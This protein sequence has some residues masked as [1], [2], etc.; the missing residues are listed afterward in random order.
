V[1]TLA[2]TQKSFD[3]LAALASPALRRTGSELR[4][5][6]LSVDPDATQLIWPKLKIASFG[7]GPK[8]N[9]QHYAYLA[10]HTNHLNLGFYHGASLQSHGLRLE[11]TGKNLRHVKIPGG[12]ILRRKALRSLLSEALEERQSNAPAV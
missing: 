12:T 5:L 2:T 4:K 11:G 10:I 1:S 8:K 9:T 7:V 3:T 6:I